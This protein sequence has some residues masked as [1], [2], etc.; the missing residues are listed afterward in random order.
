MIKEKK[1][2]VVKIDFNFLKRV[3]EFI[4]REEN[5]FR[6]VNKKQFIDIAV[7][8]F[9]KKNNKGKRYIDR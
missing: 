3:E 5:E 8:E 2:S 7:Y 9:L 4:R 6:F 1:P